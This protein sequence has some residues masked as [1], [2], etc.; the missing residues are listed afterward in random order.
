MKKIKVFM[1]IVT[2]VLV[3][4]ITVFGASYEMYADKLSTIGVLRELKMVMS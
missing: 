1:L 3:T 4:N 2:I